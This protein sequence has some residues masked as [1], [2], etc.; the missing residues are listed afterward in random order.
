MSQASLTL[1]SLNRYFSLTKTFGGQR[2]GKMAYQSIT[3]ISDFFLQK[4]YL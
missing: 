3:T 1:L 2:N 4:G